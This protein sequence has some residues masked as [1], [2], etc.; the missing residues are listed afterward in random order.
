MKG[1]IMSKQN[2]PLPDFLIHM[3]NNEEPD[4]RNNKSLTNIDCA[5]FFI[6]EAVVEIL[7]NK[8]CSEIIEEKSLDIW[9]C[10]E[11]ISKELER[12]V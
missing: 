2:T 4:P 8:N 11:D 3:Q 9:G 6:Y 1:N 5:L 12:D 7:N 10:A